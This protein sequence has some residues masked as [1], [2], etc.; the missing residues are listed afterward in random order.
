MCW[1]HWHKESLK[2]GII[3]AQQLTLKS[4]KGTIKCTS[5]GHLVLSVVLRLVFGAVQTEPNDW[6]VGTN[7]E[8]GMV[9][10]TEINQLLGQ[11]RLRESRTTDLPGQTNNNH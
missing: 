1:K 11:D 2:Q 6:R 4:S 9:K 7:Y 5:A 8:P 3:L 10:F